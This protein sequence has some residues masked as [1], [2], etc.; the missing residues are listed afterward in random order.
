MHRLAPGQRY[1]VERSCTRC[2][3]IGHGAIRVTGPRVWAS[4]S[5]GDGWLVAAGCDT[6][7]VGV[8]VEPAGGVCAAVVSQVALHPLES[9]ADDLQA[10]RIWV[11][12]EAVLKAF[13]LGLTVDPRRVRLGGPDE[14][15]RVLET[16]LDSG[17]AAGPVTGRAAGP[18]TGRAGRGVPQRQVRLMD[19]A[20]PEGLCGAVAVLADRAVEL[21][22]VTTAAAD[23]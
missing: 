7:P 14:P 16:G 18:V 6:G 21:S 11:R 20:L 4:V 9:V 5:R 8:D 2:G 3:S 15:P 22:L 13:G 10:T 1:A 23:G 19:L 12:K 17:P